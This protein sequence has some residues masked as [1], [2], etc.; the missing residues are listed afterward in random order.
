MDYSTQFIRIFSKEAAR[1]R[2]AIDSN[3]VT[4]EA[5]TYERRRPAIDLEYITS[6]AAEYERERKAQLLAR[7]VVARQAWE[8]AYAAEFAAKT[9]YME[10]IAAYDPEII[11]D[12]LRRN[13]RR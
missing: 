2:R 12:N 5:D 7:V 13:G 6:E 3:Q 4:S 10:A 11:A 1:E 9:R 8:D